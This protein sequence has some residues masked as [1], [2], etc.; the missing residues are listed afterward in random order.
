MTP[1]RAFIAI[2]LDDAL[3]RDL[4]TLRTRIDA[5]RAGVRWMTAG[6]MHL[7]LKFLGDLDERRLPELC[8]AL[9]QIAAKH[10]PF[11]MRLTGAGC[12]PPCGTVR[13]VWAGL[14]EPTGRLASLQRDIEVGMAELGFPREHRGFAPHVTLARVRSARHAGP[15]R[16]AVA[17]AA[18]FAGGAMD[19]K[20]IVLFQSI[21]S[22]D[23]ASYVPLSRHVLGAV[24]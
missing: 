15:L 10:D 14:E 5:G 7:T 12:F 13:I 20:E 3:I 23:G 2:E 22:R 1:L 19:V 4:T 16:E 24:S 9:T 21:L 6:Q 8:R 18:N 11:E 17:A